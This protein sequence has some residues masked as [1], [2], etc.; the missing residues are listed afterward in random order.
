MSGLQEGWAPL[1]ATLPGRRGVHWRSF[2]PHFTAARGDVVNPCE[3]HNAHVTLSSFTPCHCAQG[4]C[5]DY[6][7][8]SKT[9]VQRSHSLSLAP[10]QQ[11]SL[12]DETSAQAS[13]RP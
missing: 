5:D 4:N 2:S 1:R 12:H 3:L 10:S 6:T 9:I 13:A 7:D 11:P 8:R